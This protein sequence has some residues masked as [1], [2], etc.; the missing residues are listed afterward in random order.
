[1]KDFDFVHF[2]VEALAKATGDDCP[3]LAKNV[4]GWME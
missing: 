2:P 1:M 4:A 3:D